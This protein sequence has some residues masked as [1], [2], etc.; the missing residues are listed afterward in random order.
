[1]KIGLFDLGLGG[2]SIVKNLKKKFNHHYIFACNSLKELPYNDDNLLIV[3]KK[4]I[5]F[6]IAKECSV[7][8]IACFTISSNIGE[9]IKNL[10]PNIKFILNLIDNK[11]NKYNKQYLILTTNGGMHSNLIKNLNAKNIHIVCTPKLAK[12]IEEDKLNAINYLRMIITQKYDYII[13]GCSHYY[14]IKKE[15]AKAFSAKV[16]TYEKQIANELKTEKQEKL[17]LEVYNLD[18][19]LNFNKFIKEV[20]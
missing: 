11:F 7:I 16:I 15:I 3:S 1:M 8:V 14:F 4:S 13:L 5:E 12:I 17:Q 18:N 6:L 20:I 19:N 9:K 10:Y 2:I